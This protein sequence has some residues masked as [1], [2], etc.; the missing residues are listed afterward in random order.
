MGASDRSIFRGRMRWGRGQWFMGSWMPYVVASGL[1]RMRERPYVIG[2]L[3]IAVGYFWAALRGDRRYEDMGFRQD[4]HRWQKERL[5]GF[6]RG[7][8]VR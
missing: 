1:F 5:R 2:G 8:G 7:R 6:F 3:L 4:L